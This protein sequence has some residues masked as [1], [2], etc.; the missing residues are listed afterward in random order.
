MDWQMIIVGAVLIVSVAVL[1]RRIYKT[2][3]KPQSLCDA[4]LMKESCGMDCQAEEPEEQ[5]RSDEQTK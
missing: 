3:K 4:C 1:I 5:H 2:V